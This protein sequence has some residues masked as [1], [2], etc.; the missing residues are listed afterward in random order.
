MP[1]NYKTIMKQ[2]VFTYEIHFKGLLPIPAL[3][4]RMTGTHGHSPMKNGY[5]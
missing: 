5:A 2:L 1:Q 4:R 3:P